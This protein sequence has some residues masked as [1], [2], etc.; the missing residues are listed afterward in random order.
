MT[1][2]FLFYYGHH[3][4]INQI[5]FHLQ[6]TTDFFLIFELIISFTEKFENTIMQPKADK[7]VHFRYICDIIYFL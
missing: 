7:I 1:E 5:I 2:L 3:P 4:C 6:E